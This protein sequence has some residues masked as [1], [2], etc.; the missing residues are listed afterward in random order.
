MNCGWVWASEVYQSFVVNVGLF[1][2]SPSGGNLVDGLPPV[3]RWYL[4][5]LSMVYMSQVSRR[6]EAGG[7]DFKNVRFSRF[8]LKSRFSSRPGKHFGAVARAAAQNEV[9][10][11]AE[12]SSLSASA[13]RVISDQGQFSFHWPWQKF[14]KLTIQMRFWVSF[15]FRL[16]ISQMFPSQIFI[17]LCCGWVWAIC[18]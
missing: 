6:R 17:E 13:R 1:S 12:T 18:R 16:V 3:S 7:E 2:T 8:R 4:S 5:C 15:L 14:G 9:T 10:R 11:R